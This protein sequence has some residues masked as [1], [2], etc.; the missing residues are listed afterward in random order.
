VRVTIT[1]H[2][3]LCFAYKSYFHWISISFG[4]FYGHLVF[5]VLCMMKLGKISFLVGVGYFPT[6]YHQKPC[7]Q[8]LTLKRNQ[9][10]KRQKGEETID[11]QSYSCAKE[12]CLG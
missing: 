4:G 12:P 2:N 8:I 7:V 10:E 6:N 5:Y 1:I 11:E 3:G 9:V